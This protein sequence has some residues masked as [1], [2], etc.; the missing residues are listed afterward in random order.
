MLRIVFRY[1]DVFFSRSTGHYVR[2]N[3]YVLLNMTHVYHIVAIG[4]I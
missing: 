4:V 3:Y 1:S 2:D